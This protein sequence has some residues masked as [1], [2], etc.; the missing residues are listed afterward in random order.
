MAKYSRKRRPV[1]YR[2]KARAATRAATAIV[3]RALRFRRTRTNARLIRP[4]AVQAAVRRLATFRP[5]R[6]A[7]PYHIPRPLTIGATPG[8]VPNM[9]T[10]AKAVFKYTDENWIS[11]Q[12]PGAGTP[13]QEIF[14]LDLSSLFMIPMFLLVA[15]NLVVLINGL[16][17]VFTSII[18]L[19]KLLLILL[20]ILSIRMVIVMGVLGFIIP[21]PLVK[22]DFVLKSLIHLRLLLITVFFL[23]LVV[24]LLIMIIMRSTILRIVISN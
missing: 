8:I 9:R 21:P 24:L 1:A 16:V 11:L 4:R 2:R 7:K 6:V 20:S 18:V 10:Y 12:A 19:T 13:S 23:L 17:L 5:Q 14:S 3:N 22:S 15:T